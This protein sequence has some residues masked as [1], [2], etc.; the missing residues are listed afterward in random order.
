MFGYVKPFVPELKVRQNELYRAVYCGLCT[1]QKKLTGFFSAFSLSYDF[2]FLALL[3]SALAGDAL[4]ACDGRC[5]YNPLKKK[6]VVGANPSMDYTAAA[7]SV[8]TYYKILDDVQDS[9]GIKKIKALLLLPFFA[10][11]RKKALK[12]G[13][14]EEEVK[15][16]L[17]RL[18][19]IE[20]KKI[21]SPD[22]A[23]EI[24]GELLGVIAAYGVEDELSAFALRE[25][26]DAIGRWIYIVDA[27]DDLGSDIKKGS[28]NPFSQSIPP[29]FD[30]IK[31][32]LQMT[33]THADELILKIKFED[34]DVSQIIKNTVLLGTSSV[35]DRVLSKAKHELETMKGNKK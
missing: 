12:I 33:L 18:S 35:E 1:R 23:A 3:R 21:P 27:V 29:N 15:E 10:P 5:A 14:P 4:I 31:N 2:V 32:T 6:K 11:A 25:I 22:L 17:Q 7:T 8:L 34:D 16:L 28:Y 30:I 24:F 9:K 26:F 19:E 13:V 20:K